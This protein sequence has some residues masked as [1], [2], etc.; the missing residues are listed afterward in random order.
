MGA[1]LSE[2]QKGLLVETLGSQ[3]RVILLFDD[4]ETGR[5]GSLK[6]TEELMHQ[7]FVKVVKLPDGAIQP[8]ELDDEQLPLLVAD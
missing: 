4:D 7:V 5:A 8:D 6:A 1:H 3:G 2:R